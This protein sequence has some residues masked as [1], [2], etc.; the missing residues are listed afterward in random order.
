MTKLLEFA[1]LEDNWDSYHAKPIELKTLK[2]VIDLY[3]AIYEKFHILPVHIAPFSGGIQ[4]EYRENSNAL[5]IEVRGTNKYAYLFI[6]GEKE[7]DLKDDRTFSEEDNVD[8]VRVFEML[9]EL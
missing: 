5:E 7:N 8:E 1:Y 3:S 2:Q 4:L 9:G 6:Q